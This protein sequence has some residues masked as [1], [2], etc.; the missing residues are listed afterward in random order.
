MHKPS[1]S[2][3]LRS[4]AVMRRPETERLPGYWK[5]KVAGRTVSIKKAS[6]KRLLNFHVTFYFFSY[7]GFYTGSYRMPLIEEV[8]GG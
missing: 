4:V 5:R 7:L 3:L 2:V 1:S 8:D 6:N